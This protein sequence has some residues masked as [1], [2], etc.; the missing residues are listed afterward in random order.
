MSS[1]SIGLL[2]YRVGYADSF[3]HHFQDTAKSVF[4]FG[5]GTDIRKELAE[6]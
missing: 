2:F 1:L 6:G 5:A 4:P 3:F